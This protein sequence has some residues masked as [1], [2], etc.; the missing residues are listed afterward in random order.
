M[1]RKVVVQRAKSLLFILEPY[2]IGKILLKQHSTGSAYDHQLKNKH[3]K[4]SA[5]FC[6]VYYWYP[7]STLR[8]VTGIQECF[9]IKWSATQWRVNTVLILSKYTMHTSEITQVKPWENLQV[10]KTDNNDYN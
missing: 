4:Y 6:Q 3:H 10:K 9:I 5:E 7:S 2:Q 1:E 8:T